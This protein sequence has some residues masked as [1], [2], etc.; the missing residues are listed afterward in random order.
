MQS[1]QASGALKEEPQAAAASEDPQKKRKAGKQPE[2]ADEQPEKNKR[3]KPAAPEP[4]DS[5]APDPKAKAKSKNKPGRP[6]KNPDAEEEKQPKAK[7]AAKAKAAKTAPEGKDGKKDGKA[8]GNINEKEE[9]EEEQELKGNIPEEA[10]GDSRHP[11]PILEDESLKG[12]ENDED[13]E[14][15]VDGEAME[16]EEE[17]AEED[18]PAAPPPKPASGAS[19]TKQNPNPAPAKT[20]TPPAGSEANTAGPTT[21]TS[22]TPKNLEKQFEDE[23]AGEPKESFKLKRSCRTLLRGIKIT[24]KM[25]DGG[26]L[27]SP[28]PSKEE[29]IADLLEGMS[30]SA[31]QV[32]VESASKEQMA[33]MFQELLAKNA[34]MKKALAAVAP[35]PDAKGKDDEDV[36]AIAKELQTQ[37][38]NPEEQEPQHG[39]DKEA[40]DDG[41]DDE[42]QNGEEEEEEEEENTS[43]VTPAPKAK[44]PPAITPSPSATPAPHAGDDD[45][46]EFALAK[47]TTHR[48]EWMAFGRRM[49][50]D[51]APRKF[52]Q[53]SQIWD[54]SKED[55]L[56][57]FRKWLAAEKNFEKTENIMVLQRE[58]EEKGKREWECL[59]IGEMVERPKIE[60]AVRKPNNAVPDEDCPDDPATPEMAD[61]MLGNPPMAAVR[62]GSGL[63]KEVKKELNAASV[64]LDLPK[65][66]E[67]RL[68]MEKHESE[69]KN[70]LELLKEFEDLDEEDDQREALAAVEIA[71]NIGRGYTSIR[72]A[73]GIGDI[74]DSDLLRNLREPDVHN[75]ARMQTILDTGHLH[76]LVLR[77]HAFVTAFRG[78][79]K[80]LKQVF[81]FD[82][83]ADRDEICW[84]CCATKGLDANSLHLGYTNVNPDAPYWDTMYQKPPWRF[85]PAYTSI[86]GFHLRLIQ[87]DL[88][89]VWHLGTGRDLAASVIVYI[90]KRKGQSYSILA[91]DNI[92]D[93]L[94]DATSKLKAFAKSRKLPLALHKLTKN[95]LGMKSKTSYPELMS[96]GYDT[97]VVL[98]WLQTLCEANR[99]LLPRELCTAVWC[100]THVMSM[101]HNAEKQLT[102]E[103]QRNKEFFGQLFMKSYRMMAQNML[104]DRETNPA[105]YST[106]MDEDSLKKLMRVLK[107]TSCQTAEQR[108]LERWLLALPEVWAKECGKAESAAFVVDQGYGSPGNFLSER[109]ALQSSR[110]E[111]AAWLETQV[112]RNRA[113]DYLKW[114]GAD[115]GQEDQAPVLTVEIQKF[116]FE[117]CSRNGPVQL[118]K[119]MLLVDQYHVDGFLTKLEPVL[120]RKAA[121]GP[122][123]GPVPNFD[124]LYLKGHSRVVTLMA[125]LAWVM[126][127]FPKLVPSLQEIQCKA[128]H[129]SNET[130]E[131]FY[132]FKIASRGSI[133]EPPSPITW[134]YAL[135]SLSGDS[136]SVINLWNSTSTRADKLQGGKYYTVKNLLDMPVEMR[137]VV[138][139]AANDMGW[140]GSPSAMKS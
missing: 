89:H 36:K 132:N 3:A 86:S 25:A 84:M 110:D 63:P 88:L 23:A 123:H 15:D 126:K 107:M 87:V 80:A 138:L 139:K 37:I 58:K 124:I 112:G 93:R 133:R 56:K 21:T 91:G 6:R 99:D 119:A 47:S 10:S 120:I 105:N 59:T 130:D 45:L 128:I 64:A 17:E 73:G 33:T 19:K 7:K 12:K 92:P 61:A 8:S 48:K 69:L 38:D 43:T 1:L 77:L 70:Q 114:Q 16:E 30:D 79:W 42:E 108:L 20:T 131:L 66:H 98:E 32:V 31:S 72:S 28:Q 101:L 118:H 115:R 24:D 103:Q 39:D 57:V 129:L 9:E 137:T 40:E 109:L 135:T 104:Q 14:E 44:P 102:V 76:T 83:Y 27:A 2:T 134:V 50:C 125:C 111:F 49:E 90:L 127:V 62:A 67:L 78:D 65:R 46:G 96:K 100:A 85:M 116:A 81:N 4:V 18:E 122:R 136:S 74:Y 22:V 82:R 94:A 54:S 113:V 13:K 106:W 75:R 34:E 5:E 117:N 29:N 68:K 55:K 140:A 35:D 11:G 51:D 71:E 121:N 41:E 52:P 53:L 95:K 60:A 26:R 97:Y